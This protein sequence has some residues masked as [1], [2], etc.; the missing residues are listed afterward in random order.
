MLHSCEKYDKVISMYYNGMHTYGSEHNLEDWEWS[1]AF[2]V[3]KFL[4]PFFDATKECSGVYYPTSSLVLHHFFYISQ[5]FQ[6]HRNLPI[7]VDVIY[8][9]ELK[10]R[11]YLE[12]LP[13][14]FLLVSVMDH[15]LNLIGTQTII[16][17]ISNFMNVELSHLHIESMVCEMYNYY[18]E[19]DGQRS[20]TSQS[21]FSI[22]IS[23]NAESL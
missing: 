8:S 5:A 4:K 1:L 21:S 23:T 7:F 16:K 19:K 12:E 2:L 10:I 14:L 17:G 22:N 20:S 3:K 6:K 13:S 11:K 15:R 18:A 9:M